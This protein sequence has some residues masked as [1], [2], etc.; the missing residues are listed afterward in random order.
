MSHAYNDLNFDIV[1]GKDGIITGLANTLRS[2][3]GDDDPSVAIVVSDESEDYR[4]EMDWIATALRDV[5]LQAHQIHPRAL[6]LQDDKLEMTT[7]DGQR[8]VDVVYRF[9]E[10]HDLPNIQK[11][12]LLVYAVK[13]RMAIITSPF[14]AHLEEKLLFAL[15]HHP[16]LHDFWHTELGDTAWT[17]LCQTLPPTW[18]IDSRPIPPTAAIDPE[19]AV[20]DHRIRHWPDLYGL[21]Q[22]RRHL[23]MKPSGFSELSW[24]SRGVTIGHDVTNEAWDAAVKQAITSFGKTPYVIQHYHQSRRVGVRYFDFETNTVKPFEGRARI[25]PYYTVQNEKACLSGVLVTVVPASS[26]VIHGSP[27]S[28]MMPATTSDNATI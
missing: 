16:E 9:F 27:V 7:V 11:I 23:V 28:V 22:R 17:R 3:A 4:D 10:L 26:K 12:D 20:G 18:L 2:V 24:G 1:G 6:R 13:H 15:F 8:P 5:G 25:C 21:S 14:K 19:L